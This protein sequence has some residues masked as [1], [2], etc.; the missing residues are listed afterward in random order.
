[1]Q[2]ALQRIRKVIDEVGVSFP[3]RFDQVGMLHDKPQT[4]C[5]RST[6]A[7]R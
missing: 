7:L 6:E 2:T 3:S 4:S 1:M 5:E